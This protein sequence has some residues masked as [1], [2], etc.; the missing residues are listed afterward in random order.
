MRS[1]FFADISHELRTPLTVIRGEAEVTLRGKDKPVAE[2][3]TALDRIIQLTEQ[4]NKL[5]G[6]LLFLSRS[7]SGTLEIIKRPIPLIDVLLEVHQEAIVLATRKHTTVTLHNRNGTLIV[8]GDPQRLRQLFMTIIDNA[9]NYTRPGG[10][11]DVFID[12]DGAYGRVVV[13]DNG[14]GI[15][16]EDLPHVFQRFYRVKQGR[17]DWLQSGSGLG[18][19]IA[20]WIAEAHNGTISIASVLD[21]GTIVTIKLPLHESPSSPSGLIGSP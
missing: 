6:D 11:V 17:Q 2:Y 8:N 12:L 20:K 5:V 1:Q 10:T 21:Q 14:I 16:E 3:K 18:L 13:A 7:E 19:P 9:V 4:L 15:P